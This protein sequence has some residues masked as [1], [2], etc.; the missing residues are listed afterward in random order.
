MNYLRALQK[1]LLA[2][3]LC[4]ISASMVNAQQSISGSFTS[5]SQTR[6]YLGAV[7]ANPQN[8]LRLVILFCGAGEDT[9]DMMDRGYINHLG[10]NS[11]VVYPQPT[12]P[13][14]FDNDASADDFQM[15]EDL[16]T[17]INAN[18]SINQND[19]CI[20]GFSN[21]AIFSYNL[22][23]DFNASPSNRAYTFKSFAIVSGAM[24]SGK[25]N[26]RDCPLANAAPLIAFHG[27]QDAIINVNGGF[28][29]PPVNL[30]YEALDTTLSF[31]AEDINGCAASPANAQLPDLVTETPNSTVQRFDYTCSSSP[32]TTFY[33]VTGGSHSWPGGNAS[34]DVAQ[35]ANQDINASQ[36]I[37]E[38]F[39][40]AAS[41]SNLELSLNPQ[42][43]SVYP[44]PVINRLTIE[45]SYPI[46][47]IEIFNTMGGSISVK[48]DNFQSIDLEQLKAGLYYVK[49]YTLMGIDIK[50]IIKE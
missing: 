1:N 41:I 44:N 23:C 42:R 18:Y 40:N 3:F 33:R 14:G 7:P 25:T 15:V 11:M 10:N 16:I 43:T 28:L 29:F 8:P 17:E 19:I 37:A 47:K 22:M 21:G 50:K 32:N 4:L 13:A 45:S 20:G 30:I 46:D 39:E 34:L 24:E 38:F 27:T 35:A 5:G 26:L 6:T 9:S 31:W 49:V 2:F 48:G 12:S 36:L